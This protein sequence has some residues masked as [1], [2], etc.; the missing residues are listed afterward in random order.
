MEDHWTMRW[1]SQFET[2]SHRE[3]SLDSSRQRREN[4][5][6]WDFSSNFLPPSVIQ[7][8]KHSLYIYQDKK[9]KKIETLI[10]Y[11]INP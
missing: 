11:F 3:V 2:F 1:R 10:S 4:G 8:F 6:K 5:I 9:K 7:F